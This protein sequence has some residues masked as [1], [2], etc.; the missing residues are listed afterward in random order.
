MTRRAGR[1]LLGQSHSPSA[2]MADQLARV[3]ASPL[4]MIGHGDRAGGAFHRLPAINTADEGVIPPSVQEKDRL[5]VPFVGLYQRLRQLVTERRDVTPVSLQPHIGDG[6]LRKPCFAVA[7]SQPNESV[8]PFL[9]LLKALDRRSCRREQH[10]RRVFGATKSCYIACVIF[11]RHIRFVGMLLLLVND[12][13]SKVFDRGEDRRPRSD[14][15]I[16][17]TA[18]NANIRVVSLSRRKPRMHNGDPF[19]VA[20]AENS[21]HLRRERD[22]GKQDDN[23]PSPPRQLVYHAENDRRLTASRNAVKQRSVRLSV[24]SQLGKRTERGGLL[25]V[26]GQ[27]LGLGRRYR[28]RITEDLSTVERQKSVCRHGSQLT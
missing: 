10:Q 12:D 24:A 19:A 28:N 11:G 18:T 20:R 27:L 26:G 16:G 5:L 14:D 4:G 21:Q 23:S 7:L 8:Y 17:K 9:C 25:R 15:Y 1:A 13:H 3:V 6:D 22:L 2:P